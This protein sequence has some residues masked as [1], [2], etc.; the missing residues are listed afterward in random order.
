MRICLWSGDPG[1]AGTAIG[2]RRRRAAFTLIEV[3][4][5][6]A[7]IALLVAI[8]LPSLTRAR[9]L[10]QA[11]VCK[12][13][14]KQLATAVHVYSAANSRLPGTDSA[15]WVSYQASSKPPN[16]AGRRWP[17]WRA[18]DSWLGLLC[19]PDHPWDVNEQQLLWNHVAA[20]VPRQGSLWRYVHDEKVYLCPTDLKG[21]PNGDDPKGGGGNGRFSYTMNGI[22]GFKAPEQIQS[23]TYVTDFQVM[24]GANVAPVQTIPAGTRVSWSPAVMTM[25]IE[26]HPWNNVNHGFVGDSWAADSYLALR[27]DPRTSG[28]MANFGYLDGH[29]ESKRYNWFGNKK[30]RAGNVSKLQGV[31]LFNEL[32]FPYNYAGN[33][34]GWENEYAFMHRFRYPYQ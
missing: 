2:A 19:P 15:W 17:N 31:D 4:V 26:E 9:Q 12:T 1:S 7:I 28:A 16:P 14:V 13:H 3:L 27:H 30:D 29:A 34:G 32:R 33:T 25:F 6:V 22:L 8:L 24:E 20:T 18:G 5:A 23:F 11:T 10:A 21:M